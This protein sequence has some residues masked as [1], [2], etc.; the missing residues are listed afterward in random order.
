LLWKTKI[1]E[2]GER[3]EGKWK[4][5]RCWLCIITTLEAHNITV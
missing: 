1:V 3:E 2:E 5:I 4:L